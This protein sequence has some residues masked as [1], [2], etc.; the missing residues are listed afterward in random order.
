MKYLLIALLATLSIGSQAG[1]DIVYPPRSEIH[2]IPSLTISDKQFLQGDKNGK[3]V[4]V[5]G[6]LRFPPKPISQKIPV[7]FL[8]HGSSGMGPN[9]DYW[10]NHFLGQGY[11]TFSMDGFTGR[12]LT[13]VGPNQ[14]LLGRLNLILDSYRAMEVLAKHPRLDPNK[15]VMMGFSRGGQATLFASVD[16]FNKLWNKS[17]T[18][19]AAHIPFYADCV[20]SYIGDNKTT[21]KPIQLHHG[22][23]DDY[24][25]VAACREYVGK[26]KAANQNVALFEYEIGPHAFDSPLGA[27]PPVVSKDAQ[28]VRACKIVEKTAGN[29]INAQTNQEFKYTDACVEVNPHVGRDDDATQKSTREIDAFLA[30]LFKG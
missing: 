23:T 6:I 19:F 26:L 20:T 2:S 21:G 9:V 28:T 22:M 1:T 3:E 7:I 11:A 29:L 8:V 5:H 10:S 27:V 18:V 15:F 17:G 30:N 24:N 12:G 16:R 4:M 13:V 14:A 25:P